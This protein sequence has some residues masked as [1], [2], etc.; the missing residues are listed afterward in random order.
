[1]LSSSPEGGAPRVSVVIAV[2]R[3]G[4][5][6]ERCLETMCAQRFD[7]Y[8]VVAVD[9]SPDDRC[10]EIAERFPAVRYVHS[11]VRLLP[12]A[13]RNLGADSARGELLLFTDPDI[14]ASPDWVARMVAAHELHGGVIVGALENHGRAWF[15]LGVHWTKFSKWMPGGEPREVDMGPTAS[16]LC[17][18]SRFEEAG[19]FPGEQLLGDVAF[20]RRLRGL[21]LTLWLSPT[22]VVAHDH[23][24]TLASFL[25]ERYVRGALF[26]RMEVEERRSSWPGRV[27]R[28]LV[29]ALPIRLGSNLAHVVDHGRRS[30]RLPELALVWPIVFVGFCAS[31]LGEARGFLAHPRSAGRAAAARTRRATPQ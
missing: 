18:R 24:Q 22:A 19:R 7:S 29:S 8:E 12:H 28:A 23:R 6:F 26:G 2:Y 21:G 20:S 14:Y 25:R 3:S 11:P 31:L 5:T 16:L 1:M 30:G 9:S 17:P 15:D 13:A 10:R 4:A 27:S